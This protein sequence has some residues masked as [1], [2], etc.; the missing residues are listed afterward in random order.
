MPVTNK[1]HSSRLHNNMNDQE[2]K[3]CVISIDV[4]VKNLAICILGKTNCSDINILFWKWYNVVGTIEQVVPVPSHKT[5]KKQ[6][7]II[8]KNNADDVDDVDDGINGTNASKN[9]VMPTGICVN[10]IRKTGKICGRKGFVNNRGR[11]YCGVHDPKNKQNNPQETQEWC[12]GMLQTLPNITNEIMNVLKAN[13]LVDKSKLQVV[14]EQQSIDNKKI[15]L[16]SHLIY[17]HFVAFFYN[18]IPVRFV[19]AYNK[20]LV[21][22]GPYIS[23]T[24]KTPYSRRKFLAKKQTEYFISSMPNMAKQWKNFFDSC[25]SKQDDISDAFLQGLHV[26]KG[27]CSPSNQNETKNRVEKPKKQI[28]QKK[29]RF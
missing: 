25:K 16:T 29:V 3:K 8:N 12:Y 28:K 14:I 22:D 4:G 2:Y 23:C 27:S 9:V 7:S 15:L 13:N 19:P 6:R 20:L 1:K 18:T 11:A 26:L 17:G 21:Y 10:V 24:L 5:K